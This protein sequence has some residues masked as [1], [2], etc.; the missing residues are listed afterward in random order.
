MTVDFGAMRCP[1][2]TVA[3]D[4][5]AQDSSDPSFDY[6]DTDVDHEFIPDTTHFLQFEKPQEC[7]EAVRRYLKQV[8]VLENQLF[9]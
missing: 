2:K 7:A 5:A 8:G 9:P 1:V 4:P 6:G 3:P